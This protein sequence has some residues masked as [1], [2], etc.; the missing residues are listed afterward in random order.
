MSLGSMPG[1][2]LILRI[3]PGRGTACYVAKKLMNLTT[4]FW[5]DKM[6][7][8]YATLPELPWCL[9]VA[10]LSSW[11]LL[12][13]LYRLIPMPC[14]NKTKVMEECF[15]S[16]TCVCVCTCVRACVRVCVCV[17]EDFP[18]V[19]NL[20]TVDF[21]IQALSFGISNV[22]RWYTISWLWLMCPLRELP[23]V[24]YMGKFN[25]PF[26]IHTYIHKQ[27]DLLLK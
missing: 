4:C 18:D 7:A 22:F 13:R 15:Q 10:P 25:V 24:K 5:S 17:C 3:R 23:E 16:A 8:L 26:W 9:D 21:E 27:Y 11:C 19:V 1:K 20:V 14:A 6:Y 2:S 12:S